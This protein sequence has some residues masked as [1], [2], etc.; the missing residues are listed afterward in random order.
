MFIVDKCVFSLKPRN[1]QFYYI[2]I[3]HKIEVLGLIES[4]Q[5]VLCENNHLIQSIRSNIESRS[6]DELQN[7]KLI[8]HADRVPQY[9]HRGQYNAPT[10][11]EVAVLLV[12]EDKGPR[13][14]VLHGRSRQLSRISELNRS[15]D[16][17]QYPLI[18]IRGEDGYHINITQ[19]QRTKTVSCMQF[20]CYSKFAVDMMAKIISERL[21]FIRNHQ[22]KKNTCG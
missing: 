20:Y 17:L 4:L 7:F 14:I 16:A 8:I 5:T 10:I 6:F 13:D 15:Y 11:D 9:E 2:I 3:S 21:H 22:K 19:N 12:N 1:M 18:F